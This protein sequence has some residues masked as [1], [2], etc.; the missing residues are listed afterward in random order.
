LLSPRSAELRATA[1]DSKQKPLPGVW[2]VLVPAAR[3]KTSN[4]IFESSDADGRV[5]LT[6][7][8]P[9]DY[10]LFAWEAIES[11]AW[12]DPEVVKAAEPFGMKLSFSESARLSAE[13]RAIPE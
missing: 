11:W 4:F 3:E 5:T 13:I 12:F 10:L 7:V 1:V 6:G 8:I 2:V 9:G